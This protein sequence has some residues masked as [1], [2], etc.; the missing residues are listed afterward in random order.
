MPPLILRVKG[1]EDKFYSPLENFHS[2]DDVFLAWR[3]SNKVRDV[4]ENGSRM[5]N[6]AWRLWYRHQLKNKSKAEAEAAAAAAAK[7][8][9]DAAAMNFVNLQQQQQYS[10]NLFHDHHW[11]Q[12]QQQQQQQQQNKPNEHVK[13]DPMDTSGYGDPF[14]MNHFT[15][16]QDFSHLFN[17]LQDQSFKAGL[18][19]DGTPWP[20]ATSEYDIQRDINFPNPV[21][22]PTSFQHN[23]DHLDNALANRM[24]AFSMQNN[25]SMPPSPTT[26]MTP[27]SMHNRPILHSSSSDSASAAG[28]STNPTAATYIP[29]EPTSSSS[30]NSIM[31]ANVF[32]GPQDQQ[33]QQQPHRHHHHHHHHNHPPRGRV[34]QHIT[35]EMEQDPATPSSSI[36]HTDPNHHMF[37][38]DL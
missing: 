7:A 24:A 10:N 17:S 32:G 14:G 11:F 37:H 19:Q 1:G 34:R 9:A 21:S 3:V 30:S 31:G 6:M 12:Q 38:A 33:Q 35:L 28:G 25:M 27:M 20:L 8:K 4:L 13:H 5:E 22:S 18:P 29:V 16:T 36:G 23:Q 15:T 2:E 26:H